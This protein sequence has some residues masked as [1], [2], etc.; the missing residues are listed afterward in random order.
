[1]QLAARVAFRGVGARRAPHAVRALSA[2]VPTEEIDQAV[3]LKQME[4]VS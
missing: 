3:A 1:M 2:P 4:K